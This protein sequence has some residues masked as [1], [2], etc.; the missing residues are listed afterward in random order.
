MAKTRKSRG[1]LAPDKYLSKDQ[2]RQLKQDVKTR[3]DRARA[4]GSYRAVINEIIVDLMLGSGLRASELCA[5]QMRDLPHSHGKN[6]LYVR[7]GKGHVSRAVEIS[8]TLANELTCFVKNYRKGA[9]P[10]SPII[11]SE[12]GYRT[13]RWTQQRKSKG[14][15][16][17]LERARSEHSGRLTYRS[18]YSKI[19]IIGRK[20]GLNRLTP[21]ML[22]H[23]YL[24]WLYN[25]EKDLLFVRDQAG[26]RDMTTTAIYAKTC[27]E[28]RRRQVEALE[29]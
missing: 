16:R 2:V 22:R 7:D 11:P 21:H 4:N 23:T 1:G 13:I 5:L 29:F 6:I 26:H 24:T 10:G 12:N 27:T 3:A 20:A 18:L 9:K 17:L 28:A 8:T 25:V 14:D 19:K 15:G